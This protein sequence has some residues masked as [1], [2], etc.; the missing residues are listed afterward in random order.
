MKN[1]IHVNSITEASRYLAEI[2]GY[3]NEIFALAL[4]MQTEETNN[5]EA[6]SICSN[7]TNTIFTKENYTTKIIQ[8]SDE[9][10][11]FGIKNIVNLNT[12]REKF[13]Q[14]EDG[15]NLSSESGAEFLIQMLYSSN[16]PGSL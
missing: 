3:D 2:L 14:N 6:S 15:I 7:N 9:L 11:E 10:K 16:A 12:T 8:L 13:L 1:I 5:M 4:L